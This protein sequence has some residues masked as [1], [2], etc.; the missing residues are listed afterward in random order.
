M[1]EEVKHTLSL[2][3]FTHFTLQDVVPFTFT[4]C[5]CVMMCDNIVMALVHDSV[6]VFVSL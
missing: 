4:V 3:N 1:G 5:V 2:H 6:H